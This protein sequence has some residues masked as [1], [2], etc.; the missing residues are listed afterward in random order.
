MLFSLNMLKENAW[1]LLISLRNSGHIIKLIF[2]QSWLLSV[3]LNKYL[4]P[5]VILHTSYVKLC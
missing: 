3:I 1:L 5:V 4:H 2:H